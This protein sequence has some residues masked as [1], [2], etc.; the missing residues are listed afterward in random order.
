MGI[1][2]RI[3]RGWG[4]DRKSIPTAAL[5]INYITNK[6]FD[7]CPVKWFD[8][9]ML[10]VSNVFSGTRR[11]LTRIDRQMA[12]HYTFSISISDLS[13]WIS[14]ISRWISDFSDWISDIFKVESVVE[15]WN[16][17]GEIWYPSG[18]V[19][20]SFGKI[21][22]RHGEGIDHF[23]RYCKS[24]I[25]IALTLIHFLRAVFHRLELIK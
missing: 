17:I 24:N 3:P 25:L 15:F 14:D 7:R 9:F 8:I 22:N 13:K 23:S 2:T 12:Y 21:W 5:P 16:S 10:L 1:H 19:R 11:H 20:N 18:N 6:A 4:G